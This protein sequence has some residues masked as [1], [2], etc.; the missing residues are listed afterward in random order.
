[1][2]SQGL[3]SQQVQGLYSQYF[4]KARVVVIFSHFHPSLMLEARLGADPFTGLRQ[5][6]PLG[7]SCI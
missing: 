7:T 4:I 5:G 3:Y 1:M 2:Q 6:A